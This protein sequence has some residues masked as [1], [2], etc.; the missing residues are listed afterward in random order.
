MN[1][2]NLVACFSEGFSLCLLCLRNSC[3]FL[4]LRQDIVANLSVDGSIQAEHGC[5][6]S[7]AIDVLTEHC[8]IGLGS[9]HQFLPHGGIY[10]DNLPYCE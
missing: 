2:S 6:E 10:M 9:G 1:I 5:K 3:Q 8:P 7:L 4:L